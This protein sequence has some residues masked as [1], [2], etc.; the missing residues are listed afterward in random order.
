MQFDSLLHCYFS[1]LGVSLSKSFS[2]YMHGA[3]HCCS[4]STQQI[5]R[6]V[7]ALSNKSFNTCEKGFAY[8]LSN[9]RFQ[10]DDHYWRMHTKMVFALLQEQE[11]L[12]DD[13]IVPIQVD[14]TSDENDF[15]I[16]CASIV[17]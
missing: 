10:I 2:L 15:L 3:L 16:M 6:Q 9:P 4:S 8:L 17:L 11:L 5:A 13:E 7:S 1:G 14:F 12:K